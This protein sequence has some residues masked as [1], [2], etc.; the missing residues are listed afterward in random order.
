[1]IKKEDLNI[2]GTFVY[3]DDELYKFTSDAILLSI[4]A[5]AKKNEVV[6]DFCSGS[7]VV[8]LNFFALNKKLVKSVAFFEMQTPFCELL[9][10]CLK[11]NK[12]EDTCTVYNTKIQDIGKEE[13]EKFSLI[14]C[15]PPYFKPTPIKE[16][17]NLSVK[18]AREE[19]SLTLPEILEKS[20]KCLKFGGR[21][22]MVHVVDRLTD[23][24]VLM[25]KYNI[26]PKRLQFVSAK[27]KAPYLFLIEGVKGGKSG[28]KVLKN[29]E[30]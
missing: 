8:G 6:A 18:M 11:D 1:M 27:N 10:K 13:Y 14:L 25:R 17:E 29:G 12:I 5:K 15:N 22:C 2:D 16:G 19:I 30:N 9:T 20:S 4:F 26:E 7:G 3:Q 28:L 23:V 24:I 21:I